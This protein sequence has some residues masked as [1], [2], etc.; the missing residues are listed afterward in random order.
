MTVI[1]L[2]LLMA[3]EHA[4]VVDIG[5]DQ[6]LVHRLQEMG[7]REQAEVTMIQSGRPCIIA[8]GNHRLSFRGDEAAQIFVEA[9]HP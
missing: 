7:L 9:T 6:G 1:P 5:G 3:G 2:E 8:I 4:R